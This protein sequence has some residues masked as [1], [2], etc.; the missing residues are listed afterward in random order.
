M[1][2]HNYVARNSKASNVSLPFCARATSNKSSHQSPKRKITNYYIPKLN[3][4]GLHPSKKVL[5]PIRP[6]CTLLP[7]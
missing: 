1:M 6:R 7:P 5:E 4:D 2:R 3:A